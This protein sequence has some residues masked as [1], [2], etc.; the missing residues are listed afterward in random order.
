MLAPSCPP[1]PTLLALSSS[2]VSSWRKRELLLVGQRRAHCLHPLCFTA[3]RRA[4]Y[5]PHHRFQPSSPTAYLTSLKPGKWVFCISFLVACFS[6]AT[7]TFLGA[8]I[9]TRSLLGQ[10]GADSDPRTVR[11]SSTLLPP[12]DGDI[13]SRF[14][15]GRRSEVS[16]YCPEFVFSFMD[17]FV[18]CCGPGLMAHIK[19]QGLMVMA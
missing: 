4:T 3:S 10:T 17:I 1:T 18:S 9:A 13:R 19:P 5:E 16:S 14:N 12:W 15:S 8:A 11:A 7:T 6:A 2:Q